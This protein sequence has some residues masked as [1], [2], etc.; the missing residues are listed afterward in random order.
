MVKLNVPN[1]TCGHCANVI[2]KAVKGV[3]PAADVKVDLPS[4]TVAITSSAQAS[5]I[6]QAVN[7]AGYPNTAG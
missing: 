1:M 6:S 5:T 7:D 3:D 2:T 4:K